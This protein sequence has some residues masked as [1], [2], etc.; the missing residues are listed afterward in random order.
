MRIISNMPPEV[1][2]L[3]M[4]LVRPHLKAILHL[5]ENHG[6]T[7]LDRG[8]ELW[9]VSVPDT[10]LSFLGQDGGLVSYSALNSQ[11]FRGNLRD[12][13]VSARAIFEMIDDE[14]R[15]IG[16]YCPGL[17]MGVES[18]TDITSVS[19]FHAD[20]PNIVGSLRLDP[21]KPYTPT[22][23]A[24]GSFAFDGDRKIRREFAEYNKALEAYRLNGYMGPEP[25]DKSTSQLDVIS[26]FNAS[27]KP[28]SYEIV[29]SEEG[30]FYQL[31]GNDLEHFPP[32]LDEAEAS[33]HRRGVHQGGY[34]AFFEA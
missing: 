12:T 8:A 30:V 34:R 15:P 13:R 16:T 1:G 31:K 18:H 11:M 14:I 10:Q 29:P 4:Q 26:A 21:S 7:G 9:D 22:E 6:L 17:V 19:L 27:L 33:I 2:R 25:A 24:V 20:P 23:F 5:F 32:E 28:N 3:D